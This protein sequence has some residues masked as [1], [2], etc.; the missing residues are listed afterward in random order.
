[1]SSKAGYLFVIAAA[2][3]WA[4]SGT[5]SKFLFAGGITPIELAQLRA[6]GSAILLAVVLGVRN[7]SLLKIAP[8]NIGYFALLGA[9]LAVTQFTYLFAISKTLVA[10]AILLQYQ[11]PV[12][13]ALYTFFVL[14]EKLATAT[15]VAMICSLL[16]CYLAVGAYSLNILSMSK[17]GII[18]GL[19]SAVTFALYSVKSEY[20]MHRYSPWTVLFYAITVAALI[21]NIVYPPFHA[22]GRSHTLATWLLIF[23][24]TVFGTILPFGFY[25]LGIQRIRP[26]HASVTATL[27]PIAAAIISYIFLNEILE[28]WQIMGAVLVIM[29]IIILQQKPQEK[30]VNHNG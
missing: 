24:V 22:F 1:M 25:N 18:S 4:I 9:L 28:L 12:V 2:L 6:A 11:A 17:A 29:A 3:L 27:E 16:G 10:V 15:V 5:A 26:A 7:P 20:G 19:C 21:W 8:K 14:R 13:V 30:N 23:F